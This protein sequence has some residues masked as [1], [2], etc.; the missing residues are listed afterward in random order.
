MVKVGLIVPVYKN[1]EGFAELMHSVDLA[2]M[3]YIIPNWQNNLGV[4]RGWNRGL[5]L[6]I[7]DRM[8]AAF[9]VNDDATFAPGSM[10]KML[11]ALSSFDLVTGYNTRDENYDHLRF[12]EFPESPD[13]ACFVV[14][15]IQ[16]V[17]RFGW[18]DESFTPAYFEDND[19]HYR[20]RMAGGRAVKHTK[21]PFFHKGSVTQNWDGH[22][23]VNG[24][25][26]EDNRRYYIWKWGGP[27]GEETRT[28]PNTA[29]QDEE[30][31]ITL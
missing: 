18:F 6:A 31:G 19:M 7:Q 23:V 1:F 12:A 13:F 11:W 15:P 25:M 4:S 9:I 10:E 5:Q 2:V 22:Q 24:S 29:E 3:P 17:H 21:A 30:E 14:D 20:I 27:P 16:F 26:F 8:D 28:I